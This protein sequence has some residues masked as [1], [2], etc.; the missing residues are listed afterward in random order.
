MILIEVASLVFQ[1]ELISSFSS[2]LKLYEVKGKKPSFFIKNG[3]FSYKKDD[4]DKVLSS[5]FYNLYKTKD[6]NF[7]QL[8]KN[9]AGKYLGIITYLD[10][11]AILTYNKN[12]N[13]QTL[14]YIEYTFNLNIYYF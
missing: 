10:N 2:R 12:Y 9:D 5:K 3:P 1:Y 7:V 4:L 13:D 14:S 11:T 8:V 6:G